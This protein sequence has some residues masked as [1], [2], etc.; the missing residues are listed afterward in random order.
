MDSKNWWDLGYCSGKDTALLVGEYRDGFQVV[1]L[2][3]FSVATYT[4]MCPG[5]DTAPKIEY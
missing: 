1:S 5:V 2:E 4:T 3:I